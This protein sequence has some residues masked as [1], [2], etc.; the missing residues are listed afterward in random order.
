MQRRIVD[1]VHAW[2]EGQFQAK[3]G[4]NCMNSPFPYEQ[5]WTQLAEK[6]NNKEQLFFNS[7]QEWQ[8]V[9]LTV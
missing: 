6:E 9:A 3:G 4:G 8:E 2:L 1:T 5:G 7:L